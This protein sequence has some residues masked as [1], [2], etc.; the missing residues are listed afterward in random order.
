MVIFIV[1]V[2]LLLLHYKRRYSLVWLPAEAQQQRSTTILWGSRRRPS[3]WLHLLS[4]SHL[5]LSLQ[6]NLKFEWYMDPLHSLCSISVS[7]SNTPI[8]RFRN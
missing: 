5:K 7:S 8:L 6:S 3:T 4:F 2:V 1:V